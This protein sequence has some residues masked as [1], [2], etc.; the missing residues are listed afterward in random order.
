MIPLEI[1][2]DGTGKWPDID[3]EGELR[4]VAALPR[5]TTSGKPTVGFK[6][7]LPDGRVVFAQTTLSLFLTAGDAFK[8][9]Y[10]DPRG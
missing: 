6:V 7:V 9:R 5:G 10:G 1:I 4:S 2:M 3:T 8:A